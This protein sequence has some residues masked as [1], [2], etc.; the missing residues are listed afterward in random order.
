MSGRPLGPNGLPVMRVAKP[1]LFVTAILVIVPALMGLCIAYFGVYARGPLATY[2][3]RIA[4]LVATDLHWACA[5]VVVFG[6][7]V[8]F[9]NGYPMAHKGR[10][11]LP[12]SG[13]LRVNPFYYKA[14]GKDAPENLIG[15][16]EDGAVGAY[17]RANRSLHHMIENNGAVLASI[18]LGA[19]VF[20]YEVF[21]TI[22]TYGLG[23]VLHQVGYTWGFGGHAIGFY[24][25]TLAGNTLE[26]LHLIIALKA[27]GL[28]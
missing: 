9:A 24:I 7:L 15:L 22:A 6:R 2:E 19:R 28:M 21:V 18:F 1:Q 8:A 20:P 27:W 16:V 17:N 11:V 26:A 25:A 14:V 23:R 4:A 5:A 10:I 13:N 3:A 12:F